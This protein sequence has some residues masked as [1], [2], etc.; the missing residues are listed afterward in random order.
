MMDQKRL[1]EA[2]FITSIVLILFSIWELSQTFRM[3][4]KATYAG[5]NNVWYVS[6]ALLPLFIGGSLLG[7]GVVLGLHSIR[8]GGAA[9]V[10]DRFRRREAGSGALSDGS[11]SLLLILLA[12]GS[13]VYLTIP[14]IDFYLAILNFLLFFIAIF[15]FDNAAFKKKF[16]IYYAG[17]TALFVALIASGIFS[18]VQ[19]L[20]AYGFD[21][22][23]LIAFFAQLVFV[24]RWSRRLGLEKQF[25][26]TWMVTVAVPTVLVPLFRYFLLVQ[27]P[28][29][30][31]IIQ[32]MNLLYYA[33]R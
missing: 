29:E 5:V 25:T 10:I 9:A 13:F 31:G 14:R 8:T 11:L 2:D 24:R 32:L 28:H 4:M 27:L 3:P 26:V 22:L 15:Y 6:P 18:A 7:L 21:I 20:F 30:G 19:G 33:I 12:F 1:R 23:F 16:G 17:A